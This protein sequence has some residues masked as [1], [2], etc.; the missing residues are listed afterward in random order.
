MNNCIKSSTRLS[1]ESS[2]LKENNLVDNRMRTQNMNNHQINNLIIINRMNRSKNRLIHSNSSLN[3]SSQSINNR[4][5]M[6]SFKQTKLTRLHTNNLLYIM[7]S[8]IQILLISIYLILLSAQ[9]SSLNAYSA[10]APDRA[11]SSLIPGHNADPQRYFPSPYIITANRLGP[12]EHSREFNVSITAKTDSFKGFILQARDFLDPD[13]LIV[14]GSFIPNL[15]TKVIK[16]KSNLPNTL[17]HNSPSDKYYTSVIWKPSNNFKDGKLIFRGTVVLNAKTFWVVDSNPVE[18]RNTDYETDS[19]LAYPATS[20]DRQVMAKIHSLDYLGCKNKS[21]FCIGLPSGCIETENCAVLFKSTTNGLATQFYFD[22]Y[23]YDIPASEG[24][25]VSAALSEDQ[26]MG[27][28]L[29]FSCLKLKNDQRVKFEV[30]ENVGNVNRV[31]PFKAHTDVLPISY[32]IKDGKIH[33]RWEIRYDAQINNKLYNFY[34]DYYYILLAKGGLEENSDVKEYHDVKSAS[35][36]MVQLRSVGII[37]S[38]LSIKRLVK[39]HGSLMVI[40]WIWLSSIAI[41]VARYYK[42]CWDE[43]TLMGVKIWFFVHR[44]LNVLTVIAGIIATIAI[45]INVGRWRVNS[46]HQY[47]GVATNLFMIFQP[48]NAM[49]RCGPQDKSRWIFNLIHWSSGNIAHICG[50]IAILFASTLSAVNL[51]NYFNI[52][53]FSFIIFHVLIHTILQSYTYHLQR[54]VQKEEIP[55]RDINLPRS[56][57]VKDNNG[58]SMKMFFLALYILVVTAITIALLVIICRN[59]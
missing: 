11:C 37:Q 57:I 41:L 59:S 34:N 54:K 19:H 46:Y 38:K 18:V 29:V 39:L 16:C 25:Y 33:C 9:F 15:F 5:S 10:G 17:T 8:N 51:P 24:K 23:G 1:D 22:L 44:G 13:N 36:T 20:P 43:Q 27:D 3:S 55:M 12:N 42:D 26:N 21:E 45:F 50:I 2:R 6:K 14:D 32:M 53:V 58:E 30:S 47:F 56:V 52:I 31:L 7:N 4:S 40:S 35:D 49:F 48:I 28:D